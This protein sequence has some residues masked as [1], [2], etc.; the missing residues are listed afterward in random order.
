MIRQ[1]EKALALEL[2]NSGSGCPYWLADIFMMLDAALQ[3]LRGSTP[4]RVRAIRGS[5]DSLPPLPADSAQLV[6][7]RRPAPDRDPPPAAA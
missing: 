4:T 7:L 5:V 6:R 1:V 3:S 2:G